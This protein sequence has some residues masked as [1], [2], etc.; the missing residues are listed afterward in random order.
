MI[1]EFGSDSKLDSAGG[2]DDAFVLS[3]KM[4]GHRTGCDQITFD[5]KAADENHGDQQTE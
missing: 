5:K 1:V 2:T 4:G 3:E